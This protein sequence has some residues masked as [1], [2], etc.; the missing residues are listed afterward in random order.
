MA[1][2]VVALDVPDARAALALVE[3][4]GPTAD[5]YKVGLELFTAE[6]PDVVRRLT[7]MGKRVFLDLKLH[8]I[9][10]TVAGA[11]ASA[12]RL[13][14]DL[15]TVHTGGGPSMLRAAAETAGS[16][17]PRLLGVTLLTS[18]SAAEVEAAWGR[19]L[20]SMRDEVIRL[21]ELALECGLPGVVA[22]PLEA[23][24]IRRRVGKALLIVTPG[25]RLA[26]GETHDQARMATPAAAVEAG[27]DLLVVGRAVTAAPDPIAAYRQIQ[28]EASG[29]HV[30]DSSRP[31]DR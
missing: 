26:G 25:I 14:V 28:A 11:V 22:S 3:R 1:E 24:A 4:L 19:T 7:G 27:A 8:D 12:S 29:P 13:G 16:T 21:A 18:L 30:P 15:L 2:L 31:D 10:T 23:E 9:P 20:Q 5:F 6:G 17:G